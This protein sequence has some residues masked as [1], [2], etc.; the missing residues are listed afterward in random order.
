M[1]KIYLCEDRVAKH[2]LTL[3]QT[4][5]QIWSIEELC[6]FII[7]YLH[8][9]DENFFSDEVLE[10]LQTELGMEELVLRLKRSNPH[11]DLPQMILSVVHQSGYLSQEEYEDFKKSLNLKSKAKPCELMKS[12]GD[13]M[14]SKGQYMKAARI[15]ESILEEN[16]R[17]DEFTGRVYYNYAMVLQTLFLFDEALQNMTHACLILD[18]EEVLKE[19]YFMWQMNPDLPADETVMSRI[20]EQQKR[21]WIGI[22]HAKEQK[23]EEMAKVQG[24][25]SSRQEL[26]HKW[27]REFRE[28]LE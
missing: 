21:E 8:L 19:W 5:I 1:G 4:G 6:Y 13:F 23:A 25:R 24:E 28:M 16:R 2:P 27:K 3:T 7:H 15:Y 11:N 20:T 9:I 17:Q 10:F 12:K 14:A 26:Y 18:N 22:W